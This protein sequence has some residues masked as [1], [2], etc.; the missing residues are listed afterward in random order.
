MHY[1][2]NKYSNQLFAYSPNAYVVF[3]FLILNIIK[4]IRYHITK[5]TL[6][7]IYFLRTLR[8]EVAGKIKVRSALTYVN[9]IK[10]VTRI[11]FRSIWQ[12][13]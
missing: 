9:V 1:L 8:S 13:S 5:M 6:N 4:K 7:K 12:G 11:L 10:K 2:H 3:F